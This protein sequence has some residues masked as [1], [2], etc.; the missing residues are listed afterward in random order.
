[1]FN[2][3][4]LTVGTTYFVVGRYTYNNGNSAA[5][6]GEIWVNPTSFGAAEASVPSSTFATT[7][8]G[9][10]ATTASFALAS[11]SGSGG[12]ATGAL[13][14]DDIRVGTTW[15][16]VTPSGQT[17]GAGTS[18]VTVNNT[19]VAADGTSTVTVTVTVNDTTGAAMSG[20]TV[21]PSVTGSANTVSTPAATDSNGQTT[22]T[23]KST[24]AETKT[25]SAAVGAV[26]ITQTQNVT[27][28]PG[29]ITSYTVTASTPQTAGTA[30]A[31]TVTAKDANANTV[32]TDS[33]TSVTMTSNGHVLFDADA[34][35]TFLPTDNVKTLA[36]G[37]FTIN[38]KDTV[39]E[40][41]TITATDGNAKTGNTGSITVN[42]GSASQ[43]Q[44]LVPGETATPGVAPGKTGTP[45]AQT[46]GTPLTVTVNAVDANWNKVTS[47]TPTVHIASSTDGAFVS[48]AD[49][50]LVSGTKNISVTFQT[51]GANTLTASDNASALTSSTSS[52]ITTAASSGIDHY[53]LTVTSPETAGSTFTVTVQAKNASNGDITS[54]NTTA[55]TLTS[56]G[57]LQ[58]DANNDGTFGDTSGTLSS[59]AF[60]FHVKDTKAESITLTAQDLAAHTGTAPVTINAAA[61]TQL[62][63]TLPGQT[64]TSGSGNSGT[65]TAQ[66][67]GTV[68]N[69]TLEAVDAFNNLDTTF[70]G[71]G[72]TVA[73]SGPGGSAS[74]YTTTVNFSGGVSTTTLATTLT[75]AETTTLTATDAGD[76]L[77]GVASSSLTV[78]AGTATKLQMILPGQTAAPGTA[79]GGTGLTGTPSTELG[80]SPFTV[81]VNAVDAN[82]NVNPGIADTVHLASSDLA[83]TLPSDTALVSGTKNLS[84]TLATTGSQ[85]LTASDV[86]DAGK[87][88]A[89]GTVTVATAVYRSALSGTW[90][91]PGTWQYSTDGGSTWSTAAVAPTAANSTSILVQSN[92]TVTVSGTGFSIDDVV[93]NSTGTLTVSG[94]TLTATGTGIDVKSGGTLTIANVASSAVTSTTGTLNFENGSTNSVQLAGAAFPTATWGTGSYARYEP[95]TTTAAIPTGLGQSFGNFI[96]NWPAQSGSAILAGA[97]G[98][99]TL[100]NSGAGTTRAAG[101]GSIAGDLEIASGSAVSLGQKPDAASD[102]LAITIGGAIKVHTVTGNFSLTAGGT[103]AGTYTLK[104]GGGIIVDSTGKLDF[105]NDGTNSKALIEITGNAQYTLNG[106]AAGNPQNASWQI[107]NNATLVLNSSFSS[108]NTSQGNFTVLSG[109]TLNCSSNTISGGAAG[110]IN[111]NLDSGATIEVGSAT[112][113]LGNITTANHTFSSG[114]NYVFN[115]TAAQVTSSFTTAPS[116]G[117]V[118]GLTVNNTAGLTLSAS[119]T[120]N[121]ALTLTAGVITNGVNTLGLGASA[122]V[123]GASASSYVNGTVN[124][125]FNTG[126]GQSFSFPVG[127][128][129]YSPVQL[130]GLNVGTAGSLSAVVTANTQPNLAT[131]AINNTKYA[132]RYWSVAPPASD[133]FALTGGSSYNAVVTYVAGDLQ[134]SANPA[135]FIIGK[136]DATHGWLLPTGSTVNS[137]SGP[138]TTEGDGFSSFSDFAVGE[139]SAPNITA[140]PSSV[141]VCSSS[142]AATF[143]V[144]ATG[145]GLTY[146]WQVSTDGGSTW[147][148]VTVGSGGTASS[149]TTNAVLAASGNK[150][151]CVVTGTFPPVAT[152]SAATL[153]VSASPA[154]FTVT[155]GGHYCAG[156][157]GV[158]IA[159]GGSASGVNYQLKNGVSNAGS[160]VA[161]TGSALDFGN[162]TA[163]GTYTVVAVDATSGCTTA[164]NGSATVTVDTAPVITTEPAS[165]TNTAGDT[166][167]FTVAATGTSLTYQWYTNGVSLADSVGHYGGTATSTLYVTNVSA[168]DILNNVSGYYCVISGTCGTTNTTTNSL[169]V[170]AAAAYIQ[171]ETAADGSGTVV[172]AQNVTAGNSITVYAIARATDHS[173]LLNDPADTWT[174]ISKT[175]G[176]VDGDLVAAP[177]GKSAVFT[178]HKTGTAV[179]HVADTGLPSAASVNSGI[180]TVVA[181]AVSASASTVSASPTSI[182][183]DGSTT[184]TI[185][186]TLSDI[187]G[188]PVSGKAVT[189]ASSRGATDSISAASGASDASG[190]VTFTVTSTTAGSSVFTATDATDSNLA[191]TQTAGVT[192]VAGAVSASVSTVSPSPAS[193]TANG[194]AT[195]TITVTLTDAHGNPVSGKTVTLAQTSGSGTPTITTVS[196]TT[197]VSGVATFTVKSTTA[198]TDVFTATDTT[199]SNLAITQTASV[200]FTAGA[201]SASASTVSASPTSV[202]AN[203]TATSTVTVTLKDANSNPVPGKTVTLAKTSGSGTPTVTTVQGTTDASGVASFTVSS[204]TAAADVFTAT[205]TTDSNLAIT[206]TATVT[207]TAGAIDHY[208]VTAGATTKTGKTFAVTVTAKDANN[209]TV[210]TDSSTV[211]T[212]TSSSGT[213]VFD[214][215]ADGTFGDNTKTL[216]SGTFSINTKDTVAQSVTITATDGNGKSGT[217][218]SISVILPLLIWDGGK[219]GT[220]A[221]DTAGNWDATT[222]LWY[223]STVPGD[224]AWDNTSSASI[225]AG[226]TAVTIAMKAAVTVNNLT[227]NQETTGGYLLTGSSFTLTF[228]GGTNEIDNTTA[229]TVYKAVTLGGAVGFTKAGNGTLIFS[230]LPAPTFTGGPLHVAAGTLQLV[231][232]DWTYTSADLQV[233]SGA[234]F[235]MNKQNAGVGGLN[236]GGVVT[237]TGSSAKT[238]TLNSGGTFSGS[239]GATTAA[240]LLLTKAGTGTETLTGTGTYTGATAVSAGGLLVNGTLAATAVSVASGATFGGTG[241]AGGSVNYASGALAAFTQGSP[242]TITG[243]LTLNSTVVHVTIPAGNSPLPQ[244]TYTLANYSGTLSG[245]AN[246]TP[247]IDSGSVASGNVASIA[248]DTTGKHIN[249]VVACVGPTATVS[250]GGTICG[251]GSSSVSAALTGTG[252]WNVTWSDGVTDTGVASSPDTRTVSPASTT[253]YTVTALTDASG[254]GSAPTLSGSALVT[255]NHPATAVV[256]SADST[257]VC[258]GTSATLHADLTGVGPWQVQWSDEV[259][260]D[261]VASSPATH[262]VTPGSTTTYTVTSVSGAS[263]GAGTPSGSATVTVSAGGVTVN[264]GPVSQSAAVGETATFSVN[265]TV[266]NPT[267]QWQTNNGSGFATD[268]SAANTATYSLPGVSVAVHN[269]LQVKCVITSGCDSSTAI[270]G[271][272]TLTVVPGDYK[273]AGSGLWTNAASVWLV[274][275]HDGNGYVAAQIYPTAA[276]ATNIVIQSGNN[277][278]NATTIA[279]GVSDLNINAGGSLVVSNVTLTINHDATTGLTYDANISGTLTVYTNAASAVAEGTGATVKFQSGSVFNLLAV[280]GTI[281]AA[282]WDANSTCTYA[283]AAAGGGTNPGGLSQ[284][285]GNFVWNWTA[286]NASAILAGALTNVQGNLDITPGTASGGGLCF[287]AKPDTAGV[288]PTLTIGGALRIHGASGGGNV[289]LGTG[290]TEAGTYKV[291]VGSGI[292]VDSTGRLDYGSG[293]GSVTVEFT[294]NGQYTLNGVTAGNPAQAIFQVDNTAT[295]ALNSPVAVTKTFTVDGTLNCGANQITGAGTFT[296]DSGATLGIGDAN[297]I[298]SSGATGNIQTATRSFSTGASYVYTGAA[299]QVV[300]SGLPATVNNLTLATGMTNSVTVTNAPGTDTPVYNVTGTLTASGNVIAYTV[301]GTTLHRGTYPVFTYGTLSGTFGT[302]V[303]VSGATTLAPTVST[304]GGEVALVVANSSPVAN[305]VTYTRAA[306]VSFKIA[307]TNLLANATDADSDSLTLTAVGTSTNG[308]TVAIDGSIVYYYDANNVTDTFTY[309]VGDGQGGT[310]TGTVTVTVAAGGQNGQGQ[311]VTVDSQTHTA[312]VNFAGIPGYSYQV[313]RS[314]N[315]TDWVTLETTNAPSNGLFQ[316]ADAFGDLGSAPSQAY[317]RLFRP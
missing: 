45:T 297:G 304:G 172:G 23:V 187:G 27:F 153:T 34:S 70:A 148:N 43:L 199:D 316:Y 209:N 312:T 311:T 246:T 299:A 233:D 257:A 151:Q 22:F 176:V 1:V 84:V 188:N 154:A 142:P 73:Y 210:T 90:S 309:T 14:L 120:A 89:S 103:A 40:S 262:T 71:T 108:T 10:Q 200:T 12:G 173:F 198:A 208:A 190:H 175:G 66:T 112:G 171:V 207:F 266:G 13:F 222:A 168:A 95:G 64:F 97:F 177:D 163:A 115:G 181:G 259:T 224:V 33:S 107:D 260:P 308:A 75:K 132:K 306:G 248:I 98:T 110:A 250:G 280:A 99:G 238:L 272:A 2:S 29:A 82:W 17:V 285:F 20:Q 166:A 76:S 162:Q 253:T 28:T 278:T 111:F 249:L 74:T 196:G 94:V 267:Y 167:Q 96:W 314:T 143:N 9:G 261:T 271:P 101:G 213:V 67:A 193:V 60:T 109:G 232:S 25:I 55:V 282:T 140:N 136:Y 4:A 91:T 36:S 65:V 156:G 134:G 62:I 164:M 265:A 100:T 212:M 252:P 305:P 69:V 281:P 202:T 286:Q 79:A 86:T 81:T 59:G 161:G 105:G 255:V 276:N 129:S 157:A 42:P 8:T 288:K 141:A 302:P 293:T 223:D 239:L 178:A 102:T 170:T 113:V 235:D 114:A 217:S 31:V 124:R 147:N 106:V 219:T 241:T 292:I 254:C 220:G 197:S 16:D 155:G 38:A 225:G 231:G 88:S 194:T 189:L 123:T 48:P 92:C 121:S 83:A 183:A 256:R 290:G 37:T 186:V 77:T 35:G 127:V 221:S 58:V 24:K 159:L 195:S 133:P 307:I 19:S 218:A 185:T 18:T 274:N 226:G 279:A 244:G 174:L 39:A 300:G 144:T 236:G 201:V 206:Q 245:T 313:Q 230:S 160:P 49:A 227:F 211:V 315:L 179:I 128:G 191:I 229:A 169:T 184:S 258:S 119:V 284:T 149:Y 131:S 139:G 6:K 126:S 214:S 3:T 204:T 135:N 273:T 234:V 291:Q 41:A 46:A 150:F 277:V 242:M 216:A 180:Q 269:G 87:T 294:G 54:D 47:A 44:I 247:V 78:N 26:N 5:D 63:V 275:R 32:T 301:A 93:V 158:D 251:G 298:T 263:C 240:N 122:T 192:F 138:Y 205:D 289:L 287:G 237:N 182:T 296:L 130:T 165:Q 15:A 270:A 57:S 7:A 52:S 104:L 303:L 85:T 125:A 61:A 152:S 203:G 51:A 310:G 21:T 72:K 243:A 80:G 30:F 11:R 118:A 68:F 215:N 145:A 50:A 295:V 283:P 56:N 146:Q 117:H 268:T 228:T 53:A 137:G 264:S 317:Y 116:A